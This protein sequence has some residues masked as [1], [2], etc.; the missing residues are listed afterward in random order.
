M[1]LEIEAVLDYAMAQPADVLLAIEVAEM[2]D[3]TI[4]ED[5]LTIGGVDSLHPVPG[6]DAIG[7]R[8]WMNAEG[9][10]RAEY[11]ATVEMDR[12]IVPLAGLA[13]APRRALPAGVIPYLWPSRYCEADRFEAFVCREFGELDGGDKILAM[14]DWIHDH[15]DYCAGTS[16]ASTTA[17][18]TFVRRQGVCRDFAHLLATFARAAGIPARLVSAYAFDLQPPDFHAVIE[19]WLDGGWRLVDATK[20]APLEGIVRIAVGRDATDISFMTVFGAAT[21]NQQSVSVTRID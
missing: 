1:R 21:L 8:T 5:L 10:F 18:D 14:A 13:C 20:L 2:F 4:V 6:D 12:V 16:D 15:L 19:V 17:A 7:R 11:R 9:P 3:Q